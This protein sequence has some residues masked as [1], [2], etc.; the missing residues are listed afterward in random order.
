L[1]VIKRAICSGLSSLAL[2]VIFLCAFARIFLLNLAINLSQAN[3]L[4]SLKQFR[5]LGTCD[6]PYSMCFGMVPAAQQN[7]II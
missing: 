5:K 7:Q 3:R 1:I 6:L 2:S 4:G